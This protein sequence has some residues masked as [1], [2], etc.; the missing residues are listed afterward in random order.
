MEI[1]KVYVLTD[2]AGRIFRCEGGYTIGNIDAPSLWVLIDEGTGDKYNLCQ[3]HYFPGGLYTE[4][5]IPRYKLMDGKAVER[6]A[7]EIEEDRA[8][9]PP[10]QPSEV[11]VL[12][13]ENADMRAA[14]D[15]IYMGV[16]T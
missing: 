9:L 16:V 6:T 2:D 7:E 3:S 8:N 13:A 4:D 1:S 12:R 15:A 14:L 5:D 10:P 11:E